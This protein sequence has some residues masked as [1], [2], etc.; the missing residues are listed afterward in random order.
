MK[1]VNVTMNFYL[2]A[3]R[4]ALLG[5]VMTY[6]AY[7]DHKTGEVSNRVWIYGF[8]GLALTLI[9]LTLTPENLAM[10]LFSMG[11]TTG[12]SLLLFYV[13]GWGGADAKAFIVIAAS[14]PM[15]PFGLDAPIFLYP[16]AVLSLSALLS[17]IGAT[18]QKNVAWLKRQV[19]FLPYTVPCLIAALF[20]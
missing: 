11:A 18:R 7:S 17:L 8:F 2:D 19:R 15:V 20:I 1:N 10:S 9:A 4:L 3:A 6:A 5:A 12:L 14:M 13:G 16:L